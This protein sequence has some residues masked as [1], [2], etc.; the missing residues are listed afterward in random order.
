MNVGVWIRPG[1]SPTKGGGFSYHQTLINSFLS[2][3]KE[4]GEN[5]FLF[6][7]PE[8]KPK[9]AKRERDFVYLGLIPR[10]PSHN[11]HLQKL[12]FWIN[13]RLL[14]RLWLQRMNKNQVSLVYYLS[15]DDLIL[16]DYPSILTLWDLG[17]YVTYPF[18]ELINGNNFQGRKKLIERD[19][20]KALLVFSESESGKRDLVKYAKVWEGKI[21]VIPMFPGEVV[22]TIVPEDKQQEILKN[23][24]LSR[25]SYFF[26]PAQFWAHKNHLTVLSALSELIKEYPD[27]KIIF[28]GSDK[29][30]KGHIIEECNKLQLCENVVFGGFVS[31]NELYTLYTNA[32]ATIMA[33]YFGQTNMP[34]IEAMHL[35]CP[36]ICSDIDGHREILGE[37]GLYFDPSNPVSLTDAMKAVWKNR[38]YYSE[39]IIQR[40]KKTIFNK[41]TAL[42]C[43][44]KFIPEAI[45]LR[46]QWK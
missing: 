46:S 43:I 5:R 11:S 22:N 21:R 31:I 45:Y 7:S 15:Q 20:K 30:N 44:D 32:M 1:Y 27:I 12:L 16:P 23:F 17:Y 3:N 38:N 10:F 18:P 25:F 4:E 29:G 19:L 6:I 34:P 2:K 8:T 35:G 13:S 37:A 14:R 42:S 41:E 33:S 9:N 24:G 28:T 36:V 26:Y 39:L 40:S